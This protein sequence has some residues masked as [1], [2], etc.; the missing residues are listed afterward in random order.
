MRTRVA[1]LA[2]ELDEPRRGYRFGP[3]S[4]ALVDFVDPPDRV[5][6]LGAGCGVIALSIAARFAHSVK[7][8]V[9]V[10]RNAELA[11]L[12]RANS[13]HAPCA[14]V[15]AGDLREL[16]N[17]GLFDLIVA[18]PPFFE[19]GAG[20]ESASE[21][22]RGATHRYAGGPLEFASAAVRHLDAD[23]SFW[24]LHPSD[25]LSE[26]L[27][28]GLLVGLAAARIVLLDARHSG[29]PYRVWVEFRRA[30]AVLEVARACVVTPR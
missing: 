3:E 19:P 16:D 10:E 28:A 21:T 17:L 23:G 20:L 5:L 2:L 27:E 11:T 13:R 25:R 22:T 18:N 29:R 12:A 6:D 1:A 15:V 4:P 7:R 24:M 30:S 14:E 8:A 26:M 9:L